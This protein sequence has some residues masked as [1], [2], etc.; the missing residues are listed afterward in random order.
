MSQDTEVV[1]VL[2]CQRQT[3]KAYLFKMYGKNR[4]TGQ[5]VEFETWWPKSQVRYQDGDKEI[6]VPEWLLEKKLEDVFG[7]SAIIEVY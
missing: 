7:P 4:I 5:Q 6:E 2:E 1:T 3:E